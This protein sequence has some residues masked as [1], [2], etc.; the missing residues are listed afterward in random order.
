MKSIILCEGADDLWF[1][2][3]YL[4]KIDGWSI[5][6]AE[7]L[8]KEY[9]IPGNG[10]HRK[11]SYMRKNNNGVAIWSV[12][13][14]DSFKE[15]L[16][17]TIDKFVKE[18]PSVALDSIVVVRD[19]DNDNENDILNSMAKNIKDGLLLRN[20]ISTMC[21]IECSNGETASTKITPVIIP[22]KEEGAIETLLMNAVREETKSGEIIYET[23][24]K[25]V[26]LLENHQEVKDYHLKNSRLILKAKYSSMIAITNPDHS[27]G[28]FQDMMLSTPWEKS[29]YVQ[30][31]FNVI[32][33]AITP[34]SEVDD[35]IRY[36]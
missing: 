12:G 25:Y 21:H 33:K 11:V 34:S 18:I 36:V 7:S 15:P 4:Y 30:K 32:L 13:G 29:T 2:S 19:R 20:G 27:T 16:H 8:W 17:I 23:A 5:K 3:Y 31:H 22:F 6:N 9:K 10:I 14:K 26:S 35:V 24:Q 1:I 28:L